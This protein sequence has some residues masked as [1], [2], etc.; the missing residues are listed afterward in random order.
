MVPERGRS[1]S[2]AREKASR[3]RKFESM[4]VW[5]AAADSD[6]PRSAVYGCRRTGIGT[7]LSSMWPAGN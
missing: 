2:A 3:R 5:V 7:L 6:R 4:T 1:P